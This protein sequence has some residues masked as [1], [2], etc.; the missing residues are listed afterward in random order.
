[1]SEVR[2]RR[3]ES[4]LREEISSLILSGKIKDPR[5]GSFII[6][7]RVEVSK[8]IH[9]AKVFISSFDSGE[10]LDASAEALNHAA[11]FVQQHVGRKLTI[12]YTP[13][14]T[15]YADRSIEQGFEITKKIRDLQS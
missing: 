7:S 13:K 3:V 11:G 6:V 15:F 9:Y 12:R 2:L 1:M 4:L 5:V 14:L 10:T 8:D